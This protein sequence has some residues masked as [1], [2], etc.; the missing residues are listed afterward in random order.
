MLPGMSLQACIPGILL[1]P[2]P[3]L[4]AAT[5]TLL[6]D[7]PGGQVRATARAL[8]SDGSI[9]A[10]TGHV[11]SGSQA[12]VWNQND[13]FVILPSISD[14][15]RS[16]VFGMSD[17][18]EVVVGEARNLFNKD[19]AVLWTR[20]RDRSYR[21]TAL[22]VPVGSKFEFGGGFPLN[23]VAYAVSGDGSIIV[24]QG[25]TNENTGGRVFEAFYWTRSTGVQAMGN[26]SNGSFLRTV[27]DIDGISTT[28]TK[29][30]YSS[31]RDID[32]SGTFAVG[33]SRSSI[34]PAPSTTPASEVF[35]FRFGEGTISGLGDLQD[36]PFSST[37][38]AISAD[39]ST[40]TGQA[41]DP[42]LGQVAFRYTDETGMVALGDLPTGSTVAT[43]LGANASG[44]VIVGR[45]T[46]ERD[47]SITNNTSR[48]FI[49]TESLGL[50]D[51]AEVAGLTAAELGPNGFL[52]EALAVSDD[53]LT[54]AGAYGDSTND[55]QTPDRHAFIIRFTAAELG[56]VEG[57]TPFTLAATL[58]LQF[59]R[60]SI[61]FPF[62]I[63]LPYSY[64]LQFSPDL[65]TSFASQVR[66]TPD[67]DR[68][69]TRADLAPGYSGTAS[70]VDGKLT[71]MPSI[72]PFGYWRLVI[73]VP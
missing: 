67:G 3:V 21:A 70:L 66:F 62:D 25:E 58:S 7:L 71:E 16:A 49:W 40:I 45:G 55:L 44:T 39:G 41:R 13:G 6:G 37:A 30:A 61:A 19:Q 27:R 51:L 18:G 63:T 4:S 31:A 73:S 9:V 24:G 26:L 2:G 69:F 29:P 20:Q 33:P 60:S 48:A 50:R 35:R 17:D 64:T 42:D 56:L 8:S 1:L 53:G 14:N 36:P 15:G 47:V 32:R 43:G 57:P 10:G 46:V 54:I 11:E 65:A 59:T 72:P 34:R 28:V 68:S 12:W 38:E 23:M 22:P 5:F 52:E